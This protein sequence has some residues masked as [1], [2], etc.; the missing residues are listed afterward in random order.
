MVPSNFIRHSF[1]V[2]VSQV[3]R[4]GVC[5]TIDSIRFPRR[6]E[7]I[8]APLTESGTRG[9]KESP[10]FIPCKSDIRGFDA[11]NLGTTVTQARVLGSDTSRGWLERQLERRSSHPFFMR[12]RDRRENK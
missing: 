8:P 9:A 6:T 10:S 1:L 7:T 2:A 12:E 5:P 4:V 3:Q 11:A